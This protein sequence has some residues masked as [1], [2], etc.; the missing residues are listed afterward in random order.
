M[1]N[2]VPVTKR[3]FAKRHCTNDKRG[4]L[5]SGVTAARNNERNKKCKHNSAG[6]FVFEKSHGRRSEQ[7]SKEQDDKP[8][9]PFAKHP[10][11]RNVG[12]WFFKCFHTAQFL[13]V[14]GVFLF[15][16]LKYV[17]DG[18]NSQEYSMSISNR[19][20]DPVELG[21]N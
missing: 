7:F 11:H 12:I 4:C 2:A 9:S 13:D 21:K 8:W 1:Q 19:K 6:Y 18:H 5:R 16:K 15:C 14:F 20:C 17:I 10:P 3:H